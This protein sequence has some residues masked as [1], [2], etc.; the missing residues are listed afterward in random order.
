MVWSSKRFSYF[1]LKRFI[2]DI[3]PDHETL[4]KSGFTPLRHLLINQFQMRANR[5]SYIGMAYL[6]LG[7]LDRLQSLK[8][9]PT[10]RYSFPLYSRSEFLKFLNFL[11]NWQSSDYIQRFWNIFEFQK[12]FNSS[13]SESKMTSS[14]RILVRGRAGRL[15]YLFEMYRTLRLN[16]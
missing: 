4:I 15:R 7:Q 3:F 16:Y 6:P 14:D 10:H 12:L 1:N 8:F 9:K 11:W 2:F 13:W 5:L